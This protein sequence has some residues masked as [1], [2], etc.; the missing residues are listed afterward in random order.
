[1]NAESERGFTLIELV[2]GLS[3]VGALLV[4]AFGGLRVGYAGW[5]RGERR[6]D[7]LDRERGLAHVLAQSIAATH[8]YLDS[9]STGGTRMLLFRGEPER[10]AF[11]TAA[12]PIPAAAPI[13]FTAVVVSL[14]GGPLPGLAIRQKVLPNR[15][16][17]E[18]GTP[19]AADST[20]T[21]VRFR[22][23]NAMEDR[24]EDRWDAERD[25][26]LPRAVEITLTTAAAGQER[27]H[28]PLIVPIR[29]T[30]P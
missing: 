4:V 16:P 22:Y 5:E 2:L 9:P 3:I 30:S 15:D 17:F 28:P 8:A 19:V 11:V 20:V 1:M 24:W 7:L 13:A 23:L 6:A 21:R 14:D 29:V 25:R 27:E 18:R 12:P 26:L 10:L